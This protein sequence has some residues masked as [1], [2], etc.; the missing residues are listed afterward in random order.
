MVLSPLST[1]A[2]RDVMA[3]VPRKRF[4]ASGNKRACRSLRCSHVKVQLVL[5]M[6]VETWTGW[7]VEMI[8]EMHNQDAGSTAHGPARYTPSLPRPHSH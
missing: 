3:K 7:V 5:H 2:G 4:R 1:T 8:V 6:K